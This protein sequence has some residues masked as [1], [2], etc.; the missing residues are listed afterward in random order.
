MGSVIGTNLFLAR[1]A[2]AASCQ[3]QGAMSCD[4]HKVGVPGVLAMLDAVIDSQPL[5]KCA[6]VLLSCM[7]FNQKWKEGKWKGFQARAFVR[8]RSLFLDFG[9]CSDA[10][11]VRSLAYPILPSL[12]IHHR[13]F[14]KYDCKRLVLVPKSLIRSAVFSQPEL[15][16]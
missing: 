7:S 13:R 11:P 4:L 14:G 5:R 3:K 15:Y 1:N 8:F 2:R 12:V 9:L 10:C 6:C 16:Q